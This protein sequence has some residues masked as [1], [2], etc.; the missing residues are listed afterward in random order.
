MGSAAVDPP[1][2]AFRLLESPRALAGFP[3]PAADYVEGALDLNELLVT[4]AP[5]TFFVRA[6]GR[7]QIDLGILDGDILQVDRSVTPCSGRLVVAVVDDTLF[8][9]EFRRK[10]GRIALMS[11]NA[12]EASVYPPVYLDEAQH[13]AI[14]GCVVSVIRKLR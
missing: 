11:N 9:K 14:W 2:R 3:S 8:V 10:G 5:A 6:S 1:R 12:A 4:N 7:S 13:H